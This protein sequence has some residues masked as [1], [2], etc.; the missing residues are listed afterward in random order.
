MHLSAEKKM[1]DSIQ[2]STNTQKKQN[3]EH[4]GKRRNGGSCLQSVCVGSS[5]FWQPQDMC[6][7]LLVTL[8]ATSVVQ[9]PPLPPTSMPTHRHTHTH[10]MHASITAYLCYMCVIYFERTESW[11]FYFFCHTQMLFMTFICDLIY[12]ISFF[13]WCYSVCCIYIYNLCMNQKS[14]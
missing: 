11:Q 10:S 8:S 6:G 5:R 13:L 9:L 12:R 14:T 7:P 2:V 3:L 4:R 1:K